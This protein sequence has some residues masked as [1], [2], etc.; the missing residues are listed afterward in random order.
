M[1]PL[2]DCGI[3]DRSLPPLIE[4][5]IVDVLDTIEP[6]SAEHRISC[7]S[8]DLPS[9]PRLFESIRYREKVDITRKPRCQTVRDRL[10]EGYVPIA[11]IEPT[12]N[13]QVERE[14]VSRVLGWLCYLHQG[15]FQLCERRIH[16]SERRQATRAELR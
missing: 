14:G 2:G 10:R 8:S 15:K 16:L 11:E 3:L 5:M 1:H 4:A 7:K 9:N 12:A 13:V 6:R